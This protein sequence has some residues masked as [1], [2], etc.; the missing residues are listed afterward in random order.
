[1]SARRFLSLVIVLLVFSTGV[2]SAQESTGELIFFDALSFAGEEGDKAR[3]DVYLS[4]PY[5]ALDFARRNEGFVAKYRAVMKVEGGGR[6]VLDTT[7][8]RTVVTQKYARTSG[9]EEALEFY[10]LSIPVYPG[11]YTASVEILDFG[12]NLL[13]RGKRN[14][15]VI[16]FESYPFSLSGLLLVS[17]IREEGAGYAITPLLTENVSLMKDGYFLFFEAYNASETDRF[18]ITARY[19]GDDGEVVWS[20]SWEKSIPAGHSQQWIRLPLEGVGRGSYVAEIVAAEA[21]NPDETIAAAKRVIVLRGTV[22][23]MPLSEVE[24]ED[25][26]KKLRYVADQTEM[27]YIR[28]AEI[29]SEKRKRFAEFWA[30]RDP[31]PGT[32]LNEAMDEYYRRIEHANKNFRSYAEGWLTDMGRVYV[33]YGPPDRIDRDPF[34]SDGK[35]RETW[36]YYGRRLQLLFVD[37]TGFDDFRLMTPVP[38]SEKYRY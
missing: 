5:T 38:L 7:F 34:A 16:D 37:Q 20:D 31:S 33:V 3:I 8:N 14:V 35:P 15:A 25:K 21:E 29:F 10:Q 12:T 18:L 1:M 22:E 13:T 27:D 9:D 2:T 24:L 19:R 6:T 30:D 36:E 26:V 4:V 11:E 23:G 32:P 28:N 17:K